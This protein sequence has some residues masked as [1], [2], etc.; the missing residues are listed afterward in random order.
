M[1][2]LRSTRLFSAL[3]ASSLVAACGSDSST[4]ADPGTGSGS[5]PTV[6]STIPASNGASV[7]L[8]TGSYIEGHYSAGSDQTRSGWGFDLRVTF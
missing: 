4:P 7:A 3:I 2:S 6:T 5:G 8:K 1:V